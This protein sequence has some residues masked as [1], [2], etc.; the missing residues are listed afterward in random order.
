MTGKEAQRIIA[1]YPGHVPVICTGDS[2]EKKKFLIPAGMGGKEFAATVLDK[3]DWADA[4][5]RI[6]LGDEVAV[7]KYIASEL[8]DKHKGADGFLHV[9]VTSNPVAMT[10]SASAVDVKE[11][12]SP[13]GASP[14][15]PSA[16]LDEKGQP[17][18]FIHLPDCDQE[19]GSG[20]V[21][22]EAKRVRKL[23]N[24]HPDHLPVLVRQ[25]ATAG[26]PQ[27]DKKLLVPRNMTCAILQAVLPK[28]LGLGAEHVDLQV[29][30]LFMGDEPILQ[31]AALSDVYE[32][33]VDE[34]D[35][36]LHLTLGIDGSKH[37]QKESRDEDTPEDTQGTQAQQLKEA[38]EAC[39]AKDA[40]LVA[41]E[42]KATAAIA[43]AEERAAA[44]EDEL[45]DKVE[46]LQIVRESFAIEKQ[47]HEAALEQAQTSIAELTAQ[48]VE[49][50]MQLEKSEQEFAKEVAQKSTAQAALEQAQTS[51]AELTA[52]QV[53]LQMQLEKS[54]QEV[55]KKLAQKST[56]QAALEE[57]QMT[58]AELTERKNIANCQMQALKVEHAQSLEEAASS[59]KALRDDHAN[60]LKDANASVEHLTRQ[61]AKESAEKDKSQAY[62]KRLAE[63]VAAL[64]E[65]QAKQ[66]EANRATATKERELEADG[67]VDLGW[68]GEGLCVDNDFEVLVSGPGG[69][70]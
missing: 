56:A 5:C 48:Q 45:R 24:K 65:A 51:I 62:A 31:D 40:I 49:L 70:R 67:F 4:G 53:E 2:N 26:L 18:V 19:T 57:A 68:D 44:A 58:I 35:G 69:R 54:E 9:L 63:R 27:I 52:Q 59:M 34:D 36:G 29:L 11:D 37:V 30:R 55:A 1:K 7:E 12:T 17:C 14:A 64:E 66:Q 6:R 47:M 28:R 41:A 43:A 38:L 42:E 10:L 23:I 50:R 8:Y 3:C 15:S 13:S 16:K 60:A 20:T 21:S 33:Y 25:A 61:M 32:Q 22:T 46:E 39:A